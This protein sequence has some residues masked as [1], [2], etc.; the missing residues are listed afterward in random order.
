ADNNLS[1]KL[2]YTFN[3][4]KDEYEGSSDFVKQ[5]IRRPKHN[6][7]IIVDYLPFEHFNLNAQLRLVG[8]RD[9]KDFSVFPVKRITLPSYLLFNFSS[10][11]KLTNEISLFG[12]IENLFNKYYEEVLYFGTL[13]RSFYFGIEVNL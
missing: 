10:A 4:T 7:N 5:L 6:A 11:Y 13:G 1:L 8:K 2:N 3:E 9:D 12:R